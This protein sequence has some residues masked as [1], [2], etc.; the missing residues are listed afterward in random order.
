MFQVRSS[1]PQ[2]SMVCQLVNIF[3]LPLDFFGRW[4]KFLTFGKWEKGVEQ[5]TVQRIQRPQEVT[6][7]E[8]PQQKSAMHL[9]GLLLSNLEI[10]V[11]R[12]CFPKNSPPTHWRMICQ[13]VFLCCLMFPCFLILYLSSEPPPSPPDISNRMEG[14]QLPTP[15]LEKH[16]F[17]TGFKNS[18]LLWSLN[19]GIPRLPKD[20]SCIC[21]SCSFLW[22]RRATIGDGDCD[23]PWFGTGFVC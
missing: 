5:T 16:R 21:R 7:I 10:I 12:L 2:Y 4:S 15:Q 1:W 23:V 11:N 9:L 8:N 14:D 3:Y 22:G 18:S 17:F 19:R 13:Y 6:L 20:V